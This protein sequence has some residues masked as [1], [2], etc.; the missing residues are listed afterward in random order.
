MAKS[1][2][3]TG[4]DS[5]D[6]KSKAKKKPAAKKTTA[7][8]SAAKK[9][10]AKKK[11][12]EDEAPAEEVVV[13]ATADEAET[14]SDDTAEEAAPEE[15][16]EEEAAPE[17]AEEEEAEEEDAEEEDAEEEDAEEEDAAPAGNV[18][19]ME[20]SSAVYARDPDLIVP[21]KPTADGLFDMDKVDESLAEGVQSASVFVR[22]RSKIMTLIGLVAT[23]AIVT[24]L[25]LGLTVE[26]YNDDMKYFLG[27]ETDA[28][29]KMISL[30]EYK[31]Q[32]ADK[33]RELAQAEDAAS[34]NR[35][36][37]I[38]LTYYPQT[39][40]VQVKQ[41]VFEQDGL[42]GTRSKKAVKTVD[43]DLG[44]EC[45]KDTDCYDPSDF[46]TYR[47]NLTI[48]LVEQETDKVRSE[49][50]NEMKIAAGGDLAKVNL[51]KLDEDV[52]AQK[53]TIQNRVSGMVEPKVQAAKTKLVGVCQVKKGLCKNPT[54]VL[55]PGQTITSIPLNNLPLFE[56][57]KHE[58]GDNKGAVSTVRTYEYVVDWTLPGYKSQTAVLTRLTS[59]GG[60]SRTDGWKMGAGNQFIWHWQGVDL[61]PNVETRKRKYLAFKT[62][63]T[64]KAGSK[65][66]DLEADSKNALLA[67][68][69]KWITK[70]LKKLMFRDL[71]MLTD[72]E[73]YLQTS[74]AA[75]THAKA[76][77]ECGAS[78][79]ALQDEIQCNKCCAIDNK[80]DSGVWSA[81]DGKIS[82]TCTV[83][84][85]EWW[86]S[87][88]D[89]VKTLFGEDGLKKWAALPAEA[90]QGLEDL[91]RKFDDGKCKPEEP[92]EG[93]APAADGGN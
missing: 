3:K 59:K 41:L 87:K 71:E 70:T 54:T 33:A 19:A 72:S 13:E 85:R 60:E 89:A 26:K 84:H 34:Q 55:M 5:K 1:D 6:A 80:A 45:A 88:W 36:G 10:V 43:L 46:E 8:K 28:D 58:S 86:Q 23:G 44:K 14:V 79:V 42:N 20:P 11:K 67:V 15:A 4:T 83:P 68:A 35:Y 91:K 66:V 39:A 37:N 65:G 17:E 90:K 22:K 81:D 30:E 18:I 61:E 48:E 63:L 56:A 29:G 38:T 27:M 31:R 51:D 53:G 52:K 2:D 73:K 93:A 32:E 9:P 21:L 16:E 75:G 77:A 12:A 82:C 64:C 25:F 76:Q 69:P 92:I 49:L 50:L 24:V 40:Q 78:S 74:D 47:K 57:D 62:E 7:K